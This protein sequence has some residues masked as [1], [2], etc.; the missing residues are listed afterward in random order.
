[1]G[2]GFAPPHPVINNAVN[3]KSYKVDKNDD[4][5]KNTGLDSIALA[6]L[7]NIFDSSVDYTSSDDF[8]GSGGNFGG[9]GASDS[10]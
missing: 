6:S 3:S 4:S 10:F 7:F 8:N 2:K 9:G 1:M 5:Y